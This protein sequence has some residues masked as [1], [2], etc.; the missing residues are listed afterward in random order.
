MELA[1]PIL[2][3]IQLSEL[4]YARVSPCSLSFF[5]LPFLTR[6]IVR[7]LRVSRKVHS[8]DSNVKRN[9]SLNV[10]SRLFVIWYA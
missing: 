2:H 1:E 7:V 8:S 9:F 4:Y 10:Q 6:G 3:F 5:L